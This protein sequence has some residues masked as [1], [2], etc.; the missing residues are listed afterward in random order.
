MRLDGHPEAVPPKWPITPSSSVTESGKCK[1]RVHLSSIVLVTPRTVK[2]STK[3]HCIRFHN[4]HFKLDRQLESDLKPIV[5]EWTTLG[6]VPEID[7]TR[8]RLLEFQDLLRD[9]AILIE[10]VEHCI[11]PT[12]PKFSKHVCSLVTLLSFPSVKFCAVFLGSWAEGFTST[13]REFE[14]LYLRPKS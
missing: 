3:Y 5:S 14:A 12:C 8:I 11:C 13:H 9:R 1:R 7:W 6:R 4:K 10:N 2:V